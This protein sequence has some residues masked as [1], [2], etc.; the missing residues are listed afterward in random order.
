MI[1]LGCVRY[2]HW[3]NEPYMSSS[4]SFWGRVHTPSKEPYMSSGG[5]LFGSK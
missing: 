1:M 3:V 5:S 2:I 4:G